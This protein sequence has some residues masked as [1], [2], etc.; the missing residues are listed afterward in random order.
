[1]II[2]G[3]KTKSLGT[4]PVALAC[5]ACG[6]GPQ[7]LV[8]QQRYFHLYW[9]P[10]LPLGKSAVAICGHCKRATASGDLALRLEIDGY[11]RDLRT[12]W[13]MFL[14]L[15]L[16]AGLVAVFVARKN[17]QRQQTTTLLEDPRAGD[18]YVVQFPTSDDGA[19]PFTYM[20]VTSVDGDVLTMQPARYRYR[21]AEQI[22]DHE[23]ESEVGYADSSFRLRRTQVLK[24]RVEAVYRHG[25][26]APVAG[27]A[28]G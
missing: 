12:P 25:A 11:R 20:R 18:V 2:F 24:D 21:R 15:L 5:D 17:W 26:A 16:I 3:T 22:T 8:G 28:A 27:A 14:G 23:T 10:T 1:M 7:V 9:L 13:T 6:S 19:L 4:R